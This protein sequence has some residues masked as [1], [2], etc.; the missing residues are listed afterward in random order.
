ML[1]SGSVPA[2]ETPSKRSSE[3]RPEGKTKRKKTRDG[4]SSKRLP[5][6]AANGGTGAGAL[7]PDSVEVMWLDDYD[8]WG[9]DF[10]GNLSDMDTSSS[11]RGRK[12]S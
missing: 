2:S 5:S 6:S 10:L 11:L 1:A 3:S 9:D 7:S 4:S 8:V 12:V